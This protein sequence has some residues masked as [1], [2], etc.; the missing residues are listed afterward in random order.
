MCANEN[1]HSNIN[2][3]STA[4]YTWMPAGSICIIITFIKYRIIPRNVCSASISIQYTSR[5]LF[6]SSSNMIGWNR[7]LLFELHQLHGIYLEHF[8]PVLQSF[9]APRARIKVLD[10]NISGK[11]SKV[12]VF[13]LV[14]EVTAVK[15]GD[16]CPLVD[17]SRS[18]FQYNG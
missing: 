11:V 13:Q 7:S 18:F 3:I 12:A 5:Y 1:H 6:C 9:A 14:F 10:L 8:L 2:R 4:L 16:R 17:F 15:D